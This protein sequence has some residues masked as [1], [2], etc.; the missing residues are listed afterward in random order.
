MRRRVW[1]AIG[2]AVVTVALVTGIVWAAV[3]HGGGPGMIVPS[4]PDTALGGTVSAPTAVC[5]FPGELAGKIVADRPAG[6]SVP[7]IPGWDVGG[8]G[9]P[10]DLAVGSD[11]VV[12]ETTDDAGASEFRR[13]THEGVPTGTTTIP[14]DI[15]GRWAL[16]D[17][18]T[19]FVID[20]DDSSRTVA[21][22]GVDGARLGSLDVPPSDETTGHFLDLQYIVWVPE[23]DGEPA[24]LIGEGAQT[25]HAMRP[26]GAYLGTLDDVPGRIIGSLGGGRIA[27]VTG[28][29]GS[30]TTSALDVLDLTTDQPEFHAVFRT[31]IPPEDDE[32]DPTITLT[33]SPYRFHSIADGPNDDG[34]LVSTA[35][36]LQW[37]DRIGVRHAEWVTGQDGFTP[38]DPAAIVERDGRYWMTVLSDD[39]T[40]RI[41][42]LTA[43]ELMQRLRAPVSYTANLD[44]ELA[45]LGLGIGGVTGV[46]F[47]HFDAGTTPTVSLRAEAGWGE[48]DG[49]DTS[50]LTMLYSV[51]GDPTLADPVVQAERS[52]TIPRGGGETALDLPEARPGAYQVD[53]KLVDSAT[54]EILSGT[55]VRYSVGAA[56]VD[57]DLGELAAGDDWGGAAPLRGVQLA[58]RLGIDS[59]RVQLSFGSLI[60][61]PSS[62]PDA[63]AIE[64]GALPGANDD[65]PFA[66]LRK[67]AEYAAE[68]DIRLIVQVADGGEAERAAIGA[69]TWAGWVGLLVSGITDQAPSITAWE[70]LNE[71]NNAF[72]NSAEYWRTVEI[73]FADAVHAVQPDA[74][75][76]GGNTLGFAED[77]WATA[78]E[79]GLCNHIDA[80]GVHPYTGWNRSWEEEGFDRA[81]E[82][83][84]ALRESVGPTCAAL[85]VWDTETGWTADSAVAYWAQ[86][87]NVARKLLWN[88]V[89]DV[90]GWTYFFSEGGWGEN[91][92]SWSLIQYRSYVKPGGLSFASVARLLD[93]RGKPE[94]VATDIPFTRIMAVP[95]D[96]AMRVAWTDEARISAVV[97]TDAASVTVT[98]QYGA[99]STV[100][101]GDEISLTSAPQFFTAP[102]EATIEL[103]APEPYGP[104]LLAGQPVEAS[105]TFAESDAQIITSGTAD[106]YRPWRS[107]NLDGEVDEKPMVTIPLAAAATIDRVAV[108]TG[109]IACCEAGL[110]RYTVSVQTAD[111]SWRIVAEQENQFWD[112]TVVFPF[113]PIEAVAVRV[114]VPWTTVRGVDVLDVNYSAFAGGLPPPF[115]GVQTSSDYV[116]SISAI[117]AYAPASPE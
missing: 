2:G 10:G 43:D 114:E 71:P 69:G 30:S 100:R 39:G 54:N 27:G 21:H 87:S 113:D 76:I 40:P 13:F 44:G 96:D 22:Y 19:L 78:E 72:D 48:L 82:G 95:G 37:L 5:G 6:D 28:A 74:L 16:A 109:N 38:A 57:L 104:D 12:V 102:S 41:A 111:G 67:A 45:Q 15:H 46:P 91:D 62:T 97:T 11:E 88:E 61:S 98:D 34:F 117:S 42:T 92:L 107:G 1:W 23:F 50:Q 99:V 79:S 90:A 49:V 77:W 36:G 93:G 52:V 59:H 64:W 7:P 63:S 60:S 9:S 83:Y 35:Y 81:G 58:A 80:V 115:M 32:L 29:D 84:D 68:H 31:P 20:S 24:L 103:T 75:V 18:G 4:Q 66:D 89:E 116:V 26:S 55:C 101:S 33:P 17:D 108:A 106:P 112:R 8:S 110:R 53:M 3:P 85:P 65:D 70:P 105:S 47:N 51:S 25:V 86:G 73:P 56:G 14:V 94:T